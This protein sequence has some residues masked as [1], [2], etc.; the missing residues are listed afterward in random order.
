MCIIR[1]ITASTLLKLEVG[2]VVCLTCF[3]THEV[4]LAY[5]GEQG[6][7]LRF[8]ARAFVDETKDRT[9]NILRTLMPQLHLLQSCAHLTGVLTVYMG[10]RG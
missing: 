2:R 4:F 9:E 3:F 10:T 5:D 1:L 8:Q 7:R 6:S